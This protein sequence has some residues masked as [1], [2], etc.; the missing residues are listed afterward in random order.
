MTGSVT[1][2]RK[3]D[4]LMMIY[5]RWHNSLAE[6]ATFQ[7][8]HNF[9]RTFAMILHNTLC[10]GGSRMGGQMPPHLVEEPDTHF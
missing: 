2:L 1:Y 4:L 10:N 7:M 8:L 5:V 3:P 6:A 9:G